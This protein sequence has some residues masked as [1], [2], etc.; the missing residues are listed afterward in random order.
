MD[1][2][3]TTFCNIGLWRDAAGFEEQ[4]EDISTSI[5]HRSSLN[6]PN[7]EECFSHP[8]A[9]ASAGQDCRSPTRLGCV[10]GVW[11]RAALSAWFSVGRGL[12]LKRRTLV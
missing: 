2:D 6:L 3:S 7:G 12:L 8:P 11:G 1:E 10:K 4:S 9:G 5:G